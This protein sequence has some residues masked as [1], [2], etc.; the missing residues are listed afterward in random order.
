MQIAAR[1]IDPKCPP[2]SRN[3]LPGGES[4]RQLKKAS[5]SSQ[6]Q[7]ARGCRLAGKKFDKR[8]RIFLPREWKLHA[9]VRPTCLARAARTLEFT[10]RIGLILPGEI[11]EAARITV[12]VM[13]RFLMIQ[14]RRFQPGFPFRSRHNE[15]WPSELANRSRKFRSRRLT[16]LFLNGNRVASVAIGGH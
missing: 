14:E 12:Q 4:E 9:L 11:S 7:L 3:F 8:Q 15:L 6:A 13:L 10:E 5:Q 2:V 16:R 1:R